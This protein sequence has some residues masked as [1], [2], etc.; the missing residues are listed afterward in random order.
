MYEMD[1]QPVF[2]FFCVGL[3]AFLCKR[4]DTKFSCMMLRSLECNCIRVSQIYVS[5]NFIPPFL[6]PL[7]PGE[8]HKSTVME[9]NGTFDL[10][11]P[12]MI[13]LKGETTR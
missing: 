8:Y 7:T 12:L 1:C 5:V 3:V 11:T 13:W 9:Y 10:S 6:C 4:P 2:L